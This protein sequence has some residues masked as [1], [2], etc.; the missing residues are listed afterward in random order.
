M[1][2]TFQVVTHQPMTTAETLVIASA[3]LLYRTKDEMMD[4]LTVEQTR[5]IDSLIRSLIMDAPIRIGQV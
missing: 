1:C 3:Q 2:Y 4:S 5:E